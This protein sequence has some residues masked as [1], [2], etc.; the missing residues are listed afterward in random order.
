MGG[1]GFFEEEGVGLNEGGGQTGVCEDG[2]GHLEVAAVERA[3]GGQGV[4][5]GFCVLFT[6]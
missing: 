2:E 3:T 4:L 1:G 6:W 5:E